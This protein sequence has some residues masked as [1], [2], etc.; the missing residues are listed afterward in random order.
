MGL[1]TEKEG[2]AATE[3][4]RT[5][6]GVQKAVRVFWSGLTQRRREALAPRQCHFERTGSK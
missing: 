3:I 6:S 4:T 2:Q 5:T 1:V